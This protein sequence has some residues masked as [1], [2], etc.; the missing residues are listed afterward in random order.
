M[1][2]LYSLRKVNFYLSLAG[3][4]GLVFCIF[5]SYEVYG[6][7]FSPIVEI[8]QGYRKDLINVYYFDEIV[9]EANPRTFQLLEND[10]ARDRKYIFYKDKIVSNADPDTFHALDE[11]YSYDEKYVYFFHT[12]IVGADPSSFEIIYGDYTRDDRNIYFRSEVAEMLD[13][14]TLQ[15]LDVE[16]N[17]IRDKNGMYQDLQEVNPDSRGFSKYGYNSSWDDFRF[18]DGYELGLVEKD[19]EDLGGGYIRDE[20]GVYYEDRLLKDVNAQAFTVSSSGLGRDDVSIFYQEHLLVGADPDNTLILD[21]DTY[22]WDGKNIYYLAEK[23]ASSE[24]MNLNE[25]STFF[26]FRTDAREFEILGWEYITDKKNLFYQ[27]MNL[28][29]YD[30]SFQIVEGKD[31]DAKTNTEYFKEGLRLEA[32]IGNW[33]LVS[34][35]SF[36]PCSELRYEGTQE[37]QGWYEYVP[38]YINQAWA[39]RVVD[40][41]VNQLPLTE[42]GR[43]IK[44][45]NSNE[46]LEKKLKKSSKK[47]PMTIEIVSFSAYCEGLPKAEMALE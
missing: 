37:V 17:I 7:Y 29:A 26:P 25:Q 24:R 8:G 5:I 10:F 1:K 15:I 40:E 4:L 28:G 42:Y 38:D 35:P 19:F 33:K 6:H 31:W 41:D 46:E 11:R 47:N 36:T 45:T 30:K 43:D 2:V 3:L 9:K 22:A 39:F 20:E 18:F 14:E 34:L 23:K 27:D 16:G 21:Y 32:V 44:L 12:P 13:P